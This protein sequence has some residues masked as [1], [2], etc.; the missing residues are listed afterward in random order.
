MKI[1]QVLSTAYLARAKD[2]IDSITQSHHK[3]QV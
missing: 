1:S 3:G 2:A